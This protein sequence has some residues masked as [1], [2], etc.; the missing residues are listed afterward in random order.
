M[1]D[2]AQKIR[3]H[4][5]GIAEEVRSLVHDKTPEAGEVGDHLKSAARETLLAARTAL[6]KAIEKLSPT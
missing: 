4:V 6:D 5:K 1:S 3:E 2:H